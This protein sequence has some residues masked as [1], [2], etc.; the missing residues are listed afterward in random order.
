MVQGS[1]EEAAQLQAHGKGWNLFAVSWS[2]QET[3]GELL[4]LLPYLKVTGEYHHNL[5][6][7]L[8]ISVWIAGSVVG[9]C[10]REVLEQGTHHNCQGREKQH[11]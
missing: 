4:S 3:L 8:V 6:P 1:Q 7:R 10:G 11:R 5:T 9:T 2:I